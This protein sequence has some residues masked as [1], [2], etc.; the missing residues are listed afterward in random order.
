[1][2]GCLVTPT[3]GFGSVLS[4]IFRRRNRKYSYLPLPDP[5]PG[6]AMTVMMIILHIFL[7]LF[8]RVHS[9]ASILRF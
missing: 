4:A 1:M 9:I 6:T 3:C 2:K 8:S 7:Q 5:F